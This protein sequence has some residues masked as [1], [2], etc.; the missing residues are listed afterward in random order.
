M[1]Y[2]QYCYTN[3]YSKTFGH[4]RFWTNEKSPL[5]RVATFF[6]FLLHHF[7][8]FFLHIM[9]IYVEIKKIQHIFIFLRLLNISHLGFLRYFYSLLRILTLWRNHHHLYNIMNVYKIEK[10]QRRKTCFFT[11]LSILVITIFQQTCFGQSLKQGKN[12]FII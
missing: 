5:Y 4:S 12:N 8:L 9:F 2:S 11:T 1:Y 3:T 7:R 6:L 10:R